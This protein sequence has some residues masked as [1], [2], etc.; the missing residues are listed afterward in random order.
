MQQAAL[1]GLKPQHVQQFSKKSVP[2]YSIS[3]SATEVLN[4]VWYSLSWKIEYYYIT[5]IK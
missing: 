4:T 3:V 1:N 2:N 5:T